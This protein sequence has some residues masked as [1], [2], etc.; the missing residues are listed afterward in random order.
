MDFRTTK[1]PND[2]AIL[3]IRLQYVFISIV[4]KFFILLTKQN[5]IEK[6]KLLNK[7][8]LSAERVLPWNQKG[9]I[10]ILVF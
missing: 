8:E 4:I 6:D 5:F 2:Q 3:V 9:L 7:Y 1:Y 10:S